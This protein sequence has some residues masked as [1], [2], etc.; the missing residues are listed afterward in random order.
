M[1]SLES[2]LLYHFFQTNTVGRKLIWVPVDP[3][4]RVEALHSDIDLLS[5]EKDKNGLLRLR[6]RGLATGKEFEFV[7]DGKRW[8]K[9]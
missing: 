3:A 7:F 5:M 6:A 1:P 9:L 8:N 2:V 4:F